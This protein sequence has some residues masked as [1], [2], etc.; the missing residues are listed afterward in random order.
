MANPTEQRPHVST[1]NNANQT[2]YYVTLV[3]AVAFGLAGAFFRFIQDSFLFTSIANILLII[4]S[5]IAFRTVF[6]IMK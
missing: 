5:F 6:R 3:I 4:G 2:H 1:D